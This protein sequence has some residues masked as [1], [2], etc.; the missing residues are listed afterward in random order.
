MGASP[1]AATAAVVD[2]A[3]VDLLDDSHDLTEAI[4]AAYGPDGLGI[5]T[6]S[7]VPSYSSL[8]MSLLQL[9]QQVAAL[10]EDVK[11]K[12][13][14]PGSKSAT[15]SD[16]VLISS[17][18]SKV[19]VN[20]V[21]LVFSTAPELLS[22]RCH[23]LPATH[24]WVVLHLYR[25]SFGWSHG[26]E[27]LGSSP[28]LLKGSYY[29][30]PLVDVPTRDANLIQRYPSYCR[31]NIW[32]SKSLPDFEA[33]FK[34]LGKLIVDVGCLLARHCD[35]Y[36]HSKNPSIPL[37]RL[38]E[39]LRRSVTHK[40]RCLYYFPP[41]VKGAHETRWCEWHKDHGSLTGLT[42]AIFSDGGRELQNPDPCCGLY[43]ENRR[44]E[45]V[46]VSIPADSIAFQ[47]GESMQLHSGGLLWATPHYVKA[48]QEVRASEVSRSTFAVFMQLFKASKSD[49][50]LA[51]L[52]GIRF[53]QPQWD[54]P[55]NL[56]P[57][58]TP[59]NVGVSRWVPGLDFGAFA[60]LT[61]DQYYS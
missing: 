46:K 57:E 53:C 61:T 19:S 38:E 21:I 2:V 50:M 7:G 12:L 39:L 45:I 6:V 33:A 58:S 49:K 32:P 1:A 22:P 27:T 25:Y 30:N 47:M 26:K 8:R 43:V 36:V 55:M 5:L 60:E 18:P 29:A 4:E 17:L 37:D 20:V 23:I 3:Y 44:K 54:E 28:D 34:K 14:D 31:P 11:A 41:D 52:M 40:A 24:Y 15:Y 35:R 51:L 13:E 48:A 42:A 16:C 56:P 9:T 59:A 10:P